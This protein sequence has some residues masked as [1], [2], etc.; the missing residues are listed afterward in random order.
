M[1]LTTWTHH[2]GDRYLV[3]GQDC[4]GKKFRRVT[5]NPLYAMGINMWRGRLWYLPKEGKRRLL[6][7]V[8]N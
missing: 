8:W 4:D 1:G 3:I 2:T 6:K 7:R 5:E